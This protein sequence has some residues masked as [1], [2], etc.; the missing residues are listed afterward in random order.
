MKV[1]NMNRTY[2]VSKAIKCINDE[3]KLARAFLSKCVAEKERL[4]NKGRLTRRTKRNREEIAKQCEVISN[5]S[6]TCLIAQRKKRLT[7]LARRRKRKLKQEETKRIN[8]E[9][10]TSQSR[11][12][13]KFS[14]T[15]ENDPDNMEPVFRKVKIKVK[16]NISKMRKMLNRFGEVFGK[17]TTR[18]PKRRNV[19]W[20]LTLNV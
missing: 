9:F 6:L 20:Y 15:I 1:N 16:G 2:T 18:A 8:D 19:K 3:I 14:E 13:K 5:Y 12:F 10:N 17:L 11:V 4:I 7:Y